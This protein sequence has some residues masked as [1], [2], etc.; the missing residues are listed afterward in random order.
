MCFPRSLLCSD[1]GQAESHKENSHFWA[2]HSGPGDSGHGFTQ[3]LRQKPGVRSHNV[4]TCCIKEK[5]S[6]QMFKAHGQLSTWLKIDKKN[7]VAYDTVFKAFNGLLFNVA[8]CL[9]ALRSQRLIQAAFL[10]N[11]LLKNLDEGEIR[12][13]T[14]CMYPTPINQGCYVIQEGTNGAQAYVLEGKSSSSSNC[15]H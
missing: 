4:P 3:E 13:I 8:S 5:N 10:K 11:D 14:A 2:R 9:H 6:P 7:Y 12:A 15:S 1:W